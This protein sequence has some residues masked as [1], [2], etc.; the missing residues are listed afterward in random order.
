MTTHIASNARREGGQGV[1]TPCVP[2]APHTASYTPGSTP[3]PTDRTAG[4]RPQH[5]AHSAHRFGRRVQRGCAAA[6]GHDT[7]E[8]TPWGPDTLV[9]VRSG[10][11]RSTHEGAP[12]FTRT[13]RWGNGAYRPGRNWDACVAHET[14]LGTPTHCSIRRSAGG[15]G[16]RRIEALGVRHQVWAWPA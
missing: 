10:S 3:N 1:P 6:A 8:H 5:T 7:A 14:R 9:P 13:P 2:R 15:G 16:E 12:H 11:R 4:T